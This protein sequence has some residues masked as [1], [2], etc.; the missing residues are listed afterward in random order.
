MSTPGHTLYR[1]SLAGRVTLLTT[2]AVGLTVALVAAGA[3]LT[4]RLQLQDT[5]DDSLLDR[6]QAAASADALQKLTVT[7]EIP[8]WALGAGDISIAF[9]STD[10]KPEVVSAD[11]NRDAPQIELGDPEYFVAVRGRG[12]SMR[13]IDTGDERFRVVAVPAQS[14]GQALVIA[15]SLDAQE[16]VLTKVG[17][18]TL[19][20]GIAGVVLAGFAGWGVARN[21]LKPVRR[22]TGAVET[23]ARTERLTPIPVEG[24]DEIARLSSAFNQ[25]LAALGASRDRQRRLV[26]DAGHELRTPLTSLRTNIDL[27]SQATATDDDPQALQLPPTARLELMDDVRAQTEELTTLIGDLV[28]LARDEP[29]THVVGTV[30]LAEL[31]EHAVAR[32]RRRAAGVVFDVETQSW[33]VVGESGTLE[34]AV[35]N[36]LDNAAKWSPP[37]ATVRVR[38]LDGTLSVDDEGP[39]IAEHD[40]PHVFERFYRSDESRSMPG[41]GLGLAIVAQAAER[42]SGT[43]RAEASAYGGARLV[44]ELPGSAPQGDAF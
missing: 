24:D 4:M 27:L 14:N 18:V 7:A 29:L 22:L 19:L 21:G 30:D 34:R 16:R 2:M 8:S 20:L 25:M 9:I 42:H 32:V 15:Q 41:S 10:P 36:L 23:I 40:R 26:A 38:L 11:R 44:L 6:A 3:Y 12:S 43:V 28:E 13:T 35:T 31:V 17:L 33:E 1:R 5:L 37:G 39:G